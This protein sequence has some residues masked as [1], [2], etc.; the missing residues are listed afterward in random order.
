MIS[1]TNPIVNQQEM[2]NM[3]SAYEYQTR[4]S[5]SA[6]FTSLSLIE[7]QFGGNRNIMKHVGSAELQGLKLLR[8][9]NHLSA[10]RQ[11]VDGTFRI[12]TSCVSLVNILNSLADACNDLCKSRGISVKISAPKKD[13]YTFLDVEKFSTAILNIITNA[14][15]SSPDKSVISITASENANNV[16]I[17]VSDSGDGF[18]KE[19]MATIFEPF[20]NSDP[21]EMQNGLGIGLYLARHIIALHGGMIA[22]LKSAS[23]DTSV[24][25]ILPLCDTKEIE[26]LETDSVSYDKNRFSTE[27]IELSPIT[28]YDYFDRKR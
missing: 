2:K 11:I 28:D 24:N 9:S 15:A 14:Y 21:S 7:Q 16:I 18:S 17:S 5:I 26:I 8:L 3:M 13:I 25:I 4:E 27:F 1:E 20:V 10:Y 6:F 12:N 23:G 19:K 22:A